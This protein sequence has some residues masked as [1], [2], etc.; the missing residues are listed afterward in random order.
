ML[1]TLS[2]SLP[3]LLGTLSA[4]SLSDRMGDV[5]DVSR[6]GKVSGLL[7]ASD[8]SVASEVAMWVMWV[9]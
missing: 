6:S 2:D 5:G 8:L 9:M 7:V 3:A 1:E 4:V